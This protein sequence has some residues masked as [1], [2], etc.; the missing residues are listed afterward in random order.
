MSN[1]IARQRNAEGARTSRPAG[2]LR[3]AYSLVRIARKRRTT[4]IREFLALM[5]S[6]QAE[7][8]R[9]PETRARWPVNMERRRDAGNHHG[10]HE[11][12]AKQ[13]TPGGHSGFS[14]TST[15]R[16]TRASKRRLAGVGL[17]IGRLYRDLDTEPCAH[18]SVHRTK[19]FSGE[20]PELVHQSNCRNGDDA[21]R[22]ER[23]RA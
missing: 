6:P 11:A 23:A 17:W 16:I 7:M 22:I 14:T 10:K 4:S 9:S 18:A 20:R 13:S 19:M 3:A 2:S 15:F 1:Y 5:I 8:G 21:L 12:Y